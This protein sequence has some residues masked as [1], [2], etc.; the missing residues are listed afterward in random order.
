[1]PIST[2]LHVQVALSLTLHQLN[3]KLHLLQHTFIACPC[4]RTPSLLMHFFV[5]VQTS[6]LP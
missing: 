5:C 6:Y 4:P 1:M 2:A 3:L